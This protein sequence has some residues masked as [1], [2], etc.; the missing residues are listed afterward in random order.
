M[1]KQTQADHVTEEMG[2]IPDVKTERIAFPGIKTLHEKPSAEI[3]E[4]IAMALKSRSNVVE[5]RYKIGE[6]IE[7]TLG[8]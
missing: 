8:K 5:L 4:A 3:A 1:Q 2:F 7:L 6:Y